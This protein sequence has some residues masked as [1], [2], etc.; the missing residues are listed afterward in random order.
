[1]PRDERN[2]KCDSPVK[3]KFKCLVDRLT[4]EDTELMLCL[5]RAILRFRC[6]QARRQSSSCKRGITPESG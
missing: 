5:V 1:M 2:A 6:N 3:A 4:E